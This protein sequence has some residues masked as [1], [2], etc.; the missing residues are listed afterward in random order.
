MYISQKCHTHLAVFILRKTEIDNL[1]EE[2]LSNY[3]PN[4]KFNFK[5]LCSN[6]KQS[7]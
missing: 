4:T 1:H 5:M 6:I 7:I 3:F 2:N